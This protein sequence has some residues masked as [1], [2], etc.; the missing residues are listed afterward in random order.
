VPADKVAPTGT[1]VIGQRHRV[2]KIG[3]DVVMLSAIAE[4]SLPLAAGVTT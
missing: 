1:P 2:G 3:H 4:S